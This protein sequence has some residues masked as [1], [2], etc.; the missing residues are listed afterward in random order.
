MRTDGTPPDTLKPRLSLSLAEARR[1]AVA[2]HGLGQPRDRPPGQRQMRAAIGRLGLLQIDSVNVLVRAHFMPL[3]SRLGA[4]D[5]SLLTR[6]AY[7][8]KSRR[9]FEYWAHE[10]CLVPV[11]MH[12]LFRWRMAAAERGEGIYS[13]LASFARQNRGLVADVLE[14]VRDRGPL[15]ASG[16]GLGSAGAAGWWGWRGPS[17]GAPSP[18]RRTR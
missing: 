15:A 2:A 10:A 7:G 16:I 1:L 13:G 3:F 18:A 8:G 9:L 6:D 17:C 4:Y 5:Q 12:P 11:D 14:R